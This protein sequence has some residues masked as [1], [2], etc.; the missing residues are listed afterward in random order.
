MY[1]DALMVFQTWLN[2]ANVVFEFI[3]SQKQVHADERAAAKQAEKEKKAQEKAAK[4][5]AK[6][7]Q[8]DGDSDDD[9]TGDE[10][11]NET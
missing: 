8:N 3:I 1:Y 7:K 2:D 4:K 10:G 5:A 6:N 11:T 9:T